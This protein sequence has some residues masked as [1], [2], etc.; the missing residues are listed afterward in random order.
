MNCENGVCQVGSGRK[1]VDPK[2]TKFD[3]AVAHRQKLID[4]AREER[5]REAG[6]VPDGEPCQAKLLDA[7]HLTQSEK[8]YADQLLTRAGPGDVIAVV[9][10][11]GS[12]EKAA[13][14]AGFAVGRWG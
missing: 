6:H 9:D 13:F 1:V 12:G 14:L 3:A 2:W 8:I 5:R 7:V 10:T 4:Q 11:L